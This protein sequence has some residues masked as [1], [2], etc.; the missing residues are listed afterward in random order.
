M[1]DK[2]AAAIILPDGASLKLT[3]DGAEVT[4]GLTPRDD[5][6]GGKGRMSSGSVGYNLT[7]KLEGA[8]G[9]RYQV[10]LNAVLIGSKS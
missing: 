1:A 8:D 5:R 9:R 6:E 2:N 3:V 4:V 10:G 7:T